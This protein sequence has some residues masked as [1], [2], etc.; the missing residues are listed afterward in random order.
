[1]NQNPNAIVIEPIES[2]DSGVCACCGNISRTVLGYAYRNDSPLAV[3]YVHWTVGR[4]DHG[5][6]FDLIIGSW[7]EESAANDRKAVSLV[8]RLID[9]SPQFMVIDAADR[10]AGQSKLASRALSRAEVVGTLLA[11]QVFTL[12]DAV[13]LRDARIAELHGAR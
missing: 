4:P 5:A 3:Y 8:C 7:G 2:A 9:G 1:M 6:N 10:P 12:V 13:W 11:E